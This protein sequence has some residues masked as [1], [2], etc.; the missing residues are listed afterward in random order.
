MYEY[1]YDLIFTGSY[2]HSTF[3]LRIN[4]IISLI[5]N[6]YAGVQMHGIHIFTLI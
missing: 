6:L 1:S 5:Q 2:F 4:A 3:V